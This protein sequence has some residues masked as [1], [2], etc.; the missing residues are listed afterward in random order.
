M[1]SDQEPRYRLVDSNGVIRGTLYGKPDGSVAIQETESGSDREVTLAPDGTFS[2]PSVE[3]ESVSTERLTSKETSKIPEELL[4]DDSAA[5]EVVIPIP[6]RSIVKI[7]ISRIE[8]S[9]S[10]DICLQLSDDGG[11]SFLTNNDYSWV[12]KT[13]LSDGTDNRENAENASE[14]CLTSV[15]TSASGSIKPLEIT[16]TS[17][18]LGNCHASWSGSAGDFSQA[19]SVHGSGNYDGSED[20]NAI[21]L[22]IESS[23]IDNLTGF[24]EIFPGAE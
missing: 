24:V 9:E 8:S 10:G 7:H 2:A 12:Y 5:S 19:I 1:V 20:I 18:T 3:T 11:S 21:R 13:E 4:I 22:F 15:T 23:T 17:P 14:F 6:D 16:I